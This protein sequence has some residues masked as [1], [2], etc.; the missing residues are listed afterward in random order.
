MEQK[1]KYEIEIDNFRQTF[2]KFKD[3][4]KDWDFFYKIDLYNDKPEEIAQAMI[5]LYELLKKEI[6]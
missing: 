1:S 6:K 2:E 3:K 4:R 5:D